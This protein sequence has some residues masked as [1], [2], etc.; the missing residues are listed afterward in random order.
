MAA[1]VKLHL[2]DHARTAFIAAGAA[3][4]CR[5]VPTTVRP[6]RTARLAWQPDVHTH[7]IPSGEIRGGRMRTARPVPQLANVV[8]GPGM[9][10]EDK[11]VAQFDAICS[12]LHKAI[13]PS[14]LVSLKT[15]EARAE[16]WLFDRETRMDFVSFVLTKASDLVRDYT[17]HVPM[18]ELFLQDELRVGHVTFKELSAPMIARWH[19]AP[20]YYDKATPVERA[21]I[22][23][24][25]DRFSETHRGRA[26]ASVVVSADNTQAVELALAKV[27]TAMGVLRFFSPAAMS[28]QLR[29]ICAPFGREKRE[30]FV[31]MLEVD[32]CADSL[33]SGLLDGY[34]ARPWHVHAG[35]VADIRKLGFD[36]A[37]QLL[38]KEKH[39]K[40]E[41]AVLSA[42]VR[43]SESTLER[44]AH[45]RLLLA[46]SALESLFL[47]NDS[48]PIGE[49]VGRRVVAVQT[50]DPAK[51]RELSRIFASTYDLRCKFVHHG[52][53]ITIDQLK[54]EF[55]VT[56]WV[57]ISA[58]LENAGKFATV[59]E[60]VGAL[61][62]QEREVEQQ[63]Q[64][65][66]K[67]PA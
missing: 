29:N 34:T 42:V 5:V 22:D 61:D 59:A 41:A 18:H 16:D 3:L 26:V 55:F 12:G 64:Q 27:E 35:E 54:P 43:Y 17:V 49:N 45:V 14:G 67:P 46:F 51:R 36:A 57:A 47:A 37:S 52:A 30:Q 40:L 2:H 7:H 39:T 33:S 63:Q 65:Q 60:F 56:A 28:A 21:S 10:L 1:T 48:E 15:V 50:R 58:V 25:H 44:R 23:E 38:A 32:G 4:K 9:G 24:E 20:F 53:T 31:A 62:R 6:P 11:D 19:H 8:I 13:R 66:P